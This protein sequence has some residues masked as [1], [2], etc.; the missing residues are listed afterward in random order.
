MSGVEI[1][2]LPK[3]PQIVPGGTLEVF[4]VLERENKGMT[5]HDRI[6]NILSGRAAQLIKDVK[7]PWLLSLKRPGGED[8]E[9]NG[10]A[11]LATL[12]EKG[13]CL[14]LGVPRGDVDGSTYQFTAPQR[15]N[16]MMGWTHWPDRSSALEP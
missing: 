14:V 2:L 12:I 4:L 15:G 3:G 16:E 11:A 8:W 7:V 5:N 9:R 10:L 13:T 1:G 6:V